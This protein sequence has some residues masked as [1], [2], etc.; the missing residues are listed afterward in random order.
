MV[1]PS[2]KAR[3]PG[4][5]ILMGEYAVLH[6]QPAIVMAIDKYIEVTLIPR[7]D[8]QLLIRSNLGQVGMTINNIVIQH[9]FFY[10]LTAL[11]QTNDL[12]SGA[13]ITITSEFSD[14]HGLGNSAAVTVALLAVLSLWKEQPLDLL[15]L[16]QQGIT[17]VHSAQGNGSGAD[18]AASVFGGTL[19]YFMEP[20]RIRTLPNVP[21]L[22]TVYSGQKTTTTEALKRVKKRQREH[23]DFFKPFYI[24]LGA[25]T[26]AA[27]DTV[28]KN[29]WFALG[30][31]MN[32][33]QMRLSQLGVSTPTID[34]I[35]KTLRAQLNILGAKLSGAGLGDCVI[36]LGRLEKNFFPQNAREKKQGVLQLDVNIQAP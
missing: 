2:F 9:P 14:K 15:Q 5:L 27:T 23:P 18:V 35:V 19:E 6:G 11:K 22:V 25:L 8:N 33:A 1:P 28:I 26:K 13:D 32:E 34:S 17:V 29:D 31:L 30:K 20:F 21:W 4:S 7:Q 12:P 10:V 36:G 24:Q 3:A 16:Y